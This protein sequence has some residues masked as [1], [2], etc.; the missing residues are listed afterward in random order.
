[1]M[2]AIRRLFRKR[3]KPIPSISILQQ[4]ENEHKRQMVTRP[5]K[6]RRAKKPV[7]VETPEEAEVKRRMAEEERKRDIKMGI[8][9]FTMP[10]KKPATQKNT[11]QEAAERIM[12]TM[13]RYL[14]EADEKERL[15]KLRRQIVA[16]VRRE[17]KEKEIG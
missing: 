9:P 6:P 7:P 15:K 10:T 8:E 1:M 2:E 13:Y 12:I 14:G 16:D 17:A 3:H 11:N 4:L 5:H